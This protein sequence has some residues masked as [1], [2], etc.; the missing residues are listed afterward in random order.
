MQGKHM[1]LLFKPASARTAS[2]L[3]QGCGRAHCMQYR[4]DLA[5]QYPN[6]P[7]AAVHMQLLK[8]QHTPTWNPSPM[9]CS[10]GG[11]SRMVYRML[12]LLVCTWPSAVLVEGKPWS[13][14]TMLALVIAVRVAQKSVEGAKWCQHGD[15][16]WTRWSPGTMFWDLACFVNELS[17]L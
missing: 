5:P 10:G 6:S 17:R 8:Q 14:S 3:C 7:A 12:L 4:R 15:T 2:L 1:L 16:G 9:A 11:L 13:L